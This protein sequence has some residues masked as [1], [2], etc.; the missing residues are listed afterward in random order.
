[1]VVAAGHAAAGLADALALARKEPAALAAS[2][3]RPIRRD[4]SSLIN[5]VHGEQFSSKCVSRHNGTPSVHFREIPRR[6]ARTGLPARDRGA[7]E[8]FDTGRTGGDARRKN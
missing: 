6:T 8:R 2:H 7:T 1:M 5:P 3:F 4:A